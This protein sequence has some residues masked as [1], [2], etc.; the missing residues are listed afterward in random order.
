MSKKLMILACVLLVLL[1]VMPLSVT[2]QAAPSA[3]IKIGF[4][5]GIVD[6]FYQV[7]ELGVNQAVADL[8]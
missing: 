5:A 4:I 2:A 8:G 1:A 7:M 6:P 3:K